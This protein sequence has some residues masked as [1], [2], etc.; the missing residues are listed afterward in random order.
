MS[1]PV[2]W[3]LFRIADLIGVFLGFLMLEFFTNS[4][5]LLNLEISELKFISEFYLTMMFIWYIL[6]G[7][8]F[9]AL[10]KLYFYVDK[11][12]LERRLFLDVWVFAYHSFII[13]VGFMLTSFPLLSPGFLAPW[14]MVLLSNVVL[15]IIIEREHFKEILTKR[16]VVRKWF[17]HRVADIFTGLFCVALFYFVMS[18]YGY[19]SDF[20]IDPLMFI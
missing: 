12:T 6:T 4:N 10:I 1:L 20:Y 7:Y 17:L 18:A 19:G 8:F 3:V 16:N 15:F 13:M 11:T 2:R 14:S 5:M 9:V